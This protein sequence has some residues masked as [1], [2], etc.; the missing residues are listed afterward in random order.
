MGEEIQAE[1]ASLRARVD[2]LEQELAALRSSPQ[3]VPPQPV[4]AIEHTEIHLTPP[5]EPPPPPPAK[6]SL[7]NRIG[8]QLFNRIGLVALLIGTTWFLKLAIDNHWIGPMGRILVGLI[9]GA[10]IILW[11]ER[12]RR[13]GV[14]GFTF[15][16]K[17]LGSGV[18]YLSLWAAFQLFH[19]V[20]APVAFGMMLLVTAWNA[21]MAWSQN[22]EQLAA[23]ALIGGFATPVLLSTGGDHEIFLFSYL[24][25][26][27]I[28]VALLVRVRNWPRLLPAAFLFTA[29]YYCAWYV[30][31]RQP[32]DSFA[33]TVIFLICFFVV[34]SSTGISFGAEEG[35]ASESLIRDLLLPLA[36]A[37]F[38]ALALIL[39]ESSALHDPDHWIVTWS[40]VLLAAVHLGLMRISRSAVAAATHLSLAIVFLALVLPIKL[41]GSWVAIGWLAEGAALLWSSTLLARRETPRPVL[42]VV[43]WLSLAILLVGVLHAMFLPEWFLRPV[44]TPFWNQRFA[45]SLAAVAALGA[46]LWMALRAH[47]AGIPDTSP[48]WLQIAGAAA[49]LF[50]L[51]ALCATVREL[52]DLWRGTA[53]EAD[54]RRALAISAFLMLYGAALL[55]VG[56]WRR[57]AFIRW[58]AL[59]LLVFTIAKVFLYDMRNLS[60]GYRVMSF[61][62]LGALLM[63][64]SFAYQRDWLSLRD[65]PASLHAE[66]KA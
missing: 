32:S 54:L 59:I 30:G 33:I 37:A 42:Y 57:T 15:S 50:N 27:N 7:E 21:Y 4:I 45:T 14:R 66:D 26:L 47:R 46:V 17:A 40:I 60:Q 2:R 61:L 8:S 44:A 55:A 52:S 36:N 18:L 16:M 28:A 49:V 10:G 35:S 34:F 64:V 19:L 41:Q 23:Y 48:S 13:Q 53:A 1:L 12:F 63:A 62:G 29:G 11:S 43:R 56:F 31:S 22:A 58:Q 25:L 51:T 20:P 38:F 3:P 24:L 39:L 6:A 65:R 9:A 5:P